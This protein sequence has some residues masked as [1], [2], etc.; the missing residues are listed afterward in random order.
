MF[1]EKINSDYVINPKTSRPVKVG[2]AVWMKL[3]KEGILKN[4]TKDKKELYELSTNDDIEKVKYE[5]NQKLPM[6][7]QAVKGRGRYSNKIVVRE[8]QPSAKDI[9]TITKK[10]T[11]RML[12]DDD[13]IKKIKSLSDD[14]WE[15]QVSNMILEEINKPTKIAKSK[16]IKIIKKETTKGKY[17]IKEPTSDYESSDEG[18]YEN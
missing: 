15:N 1:Q 6:T 3:I 2:S 5:I 16:P 17:K 11:S 9:L 10:S 8:K 18:F 4:N 12:Q 7:Q 14:D 13:N